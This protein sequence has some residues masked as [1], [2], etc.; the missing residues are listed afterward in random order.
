MLT[1]SYRATKGF[2]SRCM[3]SS[4]RIGSPPRIYTVEG[5]GEGRVDERGFTCA[6]MD[7]TARTV[8]LW[9]DCDAGIDDAQ[10]HPWLSW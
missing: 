8:K 5:D 7:G 2:F 10:G 1:A 4:V 9:I 6:Q 3:C